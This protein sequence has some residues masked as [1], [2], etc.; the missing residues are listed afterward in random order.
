ML[1]LLLHNRLQLRT[2]AVAQVVNL[3]HCICIGTAYCHELHSSQ[4][5]MQRDRPASLA[6]QPPWL[7][8]D[9]LE[10]RSCSKC[11]KPGSLAPQSCAIRQAACQGLAAKRDPKK[12][13]AS[14]S[15][16]LPAC[17]R[18]TLVLKF[19]NEACKS[20]FAAMLCYELPRM[21]PFC[22]EPAEYSGHPAYGAVRKAHILPRF[23]GRVRSNFMSLVVASAWASAALTCPGILNL[24][25]APQQRVCT[26]KCP[27][28]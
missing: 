16:S 1:N 10:M 14:R 2:A 12:V 5:Q 26:T 25:C 13:S 24:A 20:T 23:L 8:L 7:L 22:I 3:E 9:R 15:S 28:L 27:P 6:C 11:T 4:S 19:A 21:P 18:P 17:N